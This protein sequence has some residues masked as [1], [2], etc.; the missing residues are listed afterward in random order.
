MANRN[1]I[2]C[3]IAFCVRKVTKTTM[4]ETKKYKY[5]FASRTVGLFT[6]YFYFLSATRYTTPIG[7]TVTFIVPCNG[8][9]Y[10]LM[11]A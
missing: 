2:T 10:G 3:T 9:V 4:R 6:I 11:S 7:G 5:C 1:A 8:A